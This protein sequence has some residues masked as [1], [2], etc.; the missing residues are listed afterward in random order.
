MAAEPGHFA[1]NELVNAA[2]GGADPIVALAFIGR[3]GAVP[4]CCGNCRDLLMTYG[5]KNGRGLVVFDGA[6]E[7]GLVR[8]TP[9]K[10]LLKEEFTPWPQTS[11]LVIPWWLWA[12]D[13]SEMASDLYNTKPVTSATYGACFITE[14]GCYSGGLLDDVSY[15][16]RFPI[17]NARASL[18]WDARRGTKR[19]N[20]KEL[21]LAQQGQMPIVPYLERQHLL[22]F[23]ATLNAYHGTNEPLPV[24]LIEAE[25]T[26]LKPPGPPHIHR[27]WRT[28]SHE[29]LP[30]PF[31]PAKL[32]IGEQLKLRAE[33]YFGERP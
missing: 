23:V 12:L 1:A 8:V 30:N 20:V 7:G 9:F 19:A 28:D 21:I 3:E 26:L 11:D 10:F 22:E 15:H 25:G 27:A 16:P 24:I 2:G 17:D 4:A 33:R 13:A 6:A 29:W 18:I 5:A 14:G 31:N 32:G